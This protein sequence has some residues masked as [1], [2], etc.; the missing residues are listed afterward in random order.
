M[1]SICVFYSY[2]MCIHTIC[3]SIWKTLSTQGNNLI[4]TIT[5]VHALSQFEDNTK[6]T[7]PFRLDTNTL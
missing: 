3:G 2:Y 4:G 7:S 1:Y 6:M 5:K